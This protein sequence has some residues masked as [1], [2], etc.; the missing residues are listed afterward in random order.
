MQ[1]KR[2][3]LGIHN[4]YAEVQLLTWGFSTCV[5]VLGCMTVHIACS[6]AKLCIPPMAVRANASFSGP[7]SLRACDYRYFVGAGNV[8]RILHFHLPEGIFFLFLKR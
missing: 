7:K 6:T 4:T 1:N 2:H 3:S 5:K 8:D